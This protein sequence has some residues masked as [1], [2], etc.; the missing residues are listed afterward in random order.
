MIPEKMFLMPLRSGL[1]R[2]GREGLGKGGQPNADA[3]AAATI[4]GLRSAVATGGFAG[5]RW[6][7]QSSFQSSKWIL[8]FS[9]QSAKIRF[10]EGWQSNVEFSTTSTTWCIV[11]R[12]GLGGPGSDDRCCRSSIAVRELSPL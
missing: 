7:F 11:G 5:Q 6:E 9:K 3:G 1:G 2:E 12:F 10:W 4:C 8:Q